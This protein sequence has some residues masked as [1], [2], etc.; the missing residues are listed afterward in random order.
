MGSGNRQ[1]DTQAVLA[2]RNPTKYTANSVQMI[3]GGNVTNSPKSAMIPGKNG[4]SLSTCFC[5]RT[6]NRR[7]MYQP[8]A[9]KAVTT[10]SA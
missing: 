3:A 9:Q 8:A 2:R 6:V 1:S 7:E 4:I 10:H 5:A